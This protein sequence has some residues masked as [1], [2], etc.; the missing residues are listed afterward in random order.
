MTEVHLHESQ[1]SSLPRVKP[2]PKASNIPG[3]FFYSPSDDGTDENLLI[4]LHGLGDTHVPFSKL[5]KSLKLPQTA[6]LSLRAP[7]QVPFLYEDA[8]QWYPS[9][10]T[11]GEM[12]PNP[13]PTPALQFLTKVVDHLTTHCKWPLNRI[14]LFGFAQGG[15][16][17]VEF[18]LERWKVSRASSGTTTPDSQAFASVVSV[19]GPLLTYPTLSTKCPTPLLIVHRSS[20]ETSIPSKDINAFKKGFENI[21]EHKMKGPKEGMPASREDWEPIMKFWS[22]RLERRKVE[23]LYDI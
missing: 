4:L 10:D 18:T 6:V 2:T 22:E 5:G 16:V 17:A 8:W 11:L 14:H 23:G 19:A 20:G 9:F 15:S 12:I 7:Q 3:T 1:A 13:N 21:T